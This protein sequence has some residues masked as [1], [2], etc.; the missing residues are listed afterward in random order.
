MVYNTTNIGVYTIM[1]SYREYTDEDVRRCASEVKSI[2]SLLKKLGLKPTGGNYANMYRTLQKLEVDVSHFTG[3]LWSKGEQLK[4]WGDYSRASILKPHLIKLRGN[5]CEECKNTHWLDRPIKLEIHHI[6][7]D[8]TNNN[9]T[10]LL[11]LCPN[12]HS[13]TDTWRKQK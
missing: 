3:K 5:Q 13:Y 10:N 2:A 1:R 12:C 6:D 7:G 4:N 9:K 8:R 11:L